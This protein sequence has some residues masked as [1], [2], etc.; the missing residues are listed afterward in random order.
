LELGKTRSTNYQTLFG[1]PSAA[2]FK[3]NVDGKFELARYVYAHAN[4]GSARARILDLEFRDGLLNAFHYAS[5]FDK[6]KTVMNSE[7][8]KQI[9]RGSSN[10]SDVLRILGK[11][12]GRALCP[13]YNADF[14]DKC[15]KGN[16]IWVWT[17]MNKLSTFGAAY[18][19]DQV[20]MHNVFISFDGNGVVTDVESSETRNF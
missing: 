13:S 6:D 16:E 12:H 7:Q 18:G 2:E 9:Q 19:G 11:P 3:E 4:M 14:K 5:S 17:A 8:L 15:G 1:K 10:K 20:E